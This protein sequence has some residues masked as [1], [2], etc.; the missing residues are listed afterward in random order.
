MLG[1][2][3]SA[4]LHSLRNLLRRVP[5]IL[6]QLPVLCLLETS[7]FLGFQMHP[8]VLRGH[9]ALSLC[10]STCIWPSCKDSSPAGLRPP[11]PV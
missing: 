2:K 7:E 1:T 11:T 4:G 9:M 6:F 5:P 3:V 8:T 10:L